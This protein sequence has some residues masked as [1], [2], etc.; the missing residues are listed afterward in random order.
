M[1][2][3]GL[4]A[5]DSRQ[6][7]LTPQWH[8]IQHLRRSVGKPLHFHTPKTEPCFRQQGRIKSRGL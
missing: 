6:L 8:G 7:A 2:C 1:A 4:E 5:E 3:L